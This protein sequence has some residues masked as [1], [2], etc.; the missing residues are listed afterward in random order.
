MLAVAAVSCS[1]DVKGHDGWMSEGLL[2]AFSVQTGTTNYEGVVDHYRRCVEI[3]G[4]EE[5]SAI[6]GVEYALATETATIWPDPQEFVGKWQKSQTVVVTDNGR[7]MAYDVIFI[8]YDEPQTNPGKPEQPEQP[9]EDDGLELV[10]S[11]E[12]DTDGEPDHDKWVLCPRGKSNWNDEM[13]ESYDQAYV[14]DGVLKLVA[15]KVDGEYRAGGIKTEG[16]AW[17]GAGHRIEVSARLAKYPN[18]AFPAIWMMPQKAAPG[19]SGWP[20]AGEI[21]IMEHVK[22]NKYVEHTI[23]SHYENVLG[24]KSNPPYTAQTTCDFAEFTHYALDF[25]ENELRIYVNGELRF[26]YWNLHLSNEAEMMQWPFGNGATFYL[27]LNMGLGGGSDAWVGNID[28]DNLPAVMEV[29]W[30]RVYKLPDEE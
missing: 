9:G 27:I 18:G 25:T 4:I 5:L 10:F 30:V 24:N 11:D 20:G 28:D 19:Y 1:N 6:T 14:E 13:S 29:D 26:R 15:E 23:H 7:E 3:G 2:K 8:L 22:Q 21:D 16:K 17:W 12:F